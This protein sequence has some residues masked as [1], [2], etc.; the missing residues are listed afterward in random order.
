MTDH[1]LQNLNDAR[2]AEFNT[3]TREQRRSFIGGMHMGKSVEEA[4]E[5]AGIGSID[6]AWEV[7]RRNY[8]QITVLTPVGEVQ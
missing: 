3:T 1:A 8:R 5:I 7:L 4:V 2:D 6:A